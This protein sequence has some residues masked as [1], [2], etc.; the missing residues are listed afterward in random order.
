MNRGNKLKRIKKIV[1]ILAI[2]LIAVIATGSVQAYADTVTYKTSAKGTVTIS[3]KEG[4]SDTDY[5]IDASGQKVINYANFKSITIINAKS[6]TE[7]A[8]GNTIV[9]KKKKAK[10]YVD[11][12]AKPKKITVSAKNVS[13]YAEKNAE[14]KSLVCKKAN[15]TLNLD[16]KKSAAVNISISKKTDIKIT[17]DSSATVNVSASVKNCK[18][19]T[20]VPVKI[21][22]GK[23][24]VINTGSS[25][26]DPDPTPEPVVSEKE[27]LAELKKSAES[28]EGYKI[29]ISSFPNKVLKTEKEV[30]DCIYEASKTCVSFGLPVANFDILHYEQYYTDKFPGIE[31]IVFSNVRKYENT[32][33]M[34]CEFVKKYAT[35]L[36]EDEY[37]V[38][39]ALLSGNVEYLTSDEKKLY[40]KVV[41]LSSDLK[42]ENEYDTVKSIHDYLV[43]KIAYD[44]DG[45][46]KAKYTLAGALNNFSC[47][48]AGYAKA[49]YF[50]GKACGLDVVI[51]SGNVTN[52][53]DGHAW[54]KVKVDGKWYNI[55]VTW[56][57]PVPDRPGNVE[58]IYFLLT[59]NDLAYDHIWDNNGLPEAKSGDL[60]YIYV[61][62]GDVIRFNTDKE[63]MEYITSGLS[64]IEESSPNSFNFEVELISLETDG[65]LLNTEISSLVNLYHNSHNCGYKTVSKDL[66]EFG[67]YFYVKIYK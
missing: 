32:Y 23:V 44:S 51:V 42:K 26:T 17:G 24:V 65:N 31:K 55:D 19:T 27:R 5:V 28:Y 41:K 15:N 35:V 59:D 52:S 33:Y 20:E 30:T 25:E 37:A 9:I 56:D 39:N 54:N 6:Y 4:N 8:S 48:C 46:D 47:V 64:K 61:T 63:A 66:K 40:N 67:R 53:S 1:S 2:A 36:Y 38:H 60:G 49:F 16:L 22:K 58:Y 18:I 12:N 21:K 29:N 57:D 13:V 34:K 3:E 10:V 50:L 7:K 45:K 11:E 14:I 43:S 62:F